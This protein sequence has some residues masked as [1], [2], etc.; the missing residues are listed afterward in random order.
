M[1][2]GA[3]GMGL[4]GDWGTRTHRGDTGWALS[5]AHP[6]TPAGPTPHIGAG[7]AFLGHV[8]IIFILSG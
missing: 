3:A 5:P 2:A 8:I 7:K 6:P 4:L 1:S